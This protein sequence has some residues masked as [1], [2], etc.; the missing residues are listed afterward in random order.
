MAGGDA[1]C[2]ATLRRYE[3]RL[4]RALASV[5]NLVDPDVIVLGGGLSN[6]AR[7]YEN[8]PSQVAPHVFADRSATPIRPPRHG[9]SSGVR[10]AA[11]LEHARGRQLAATTMASPSAAIVAVRPQ[12]RANS[13][14]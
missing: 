8:V 2:E 12:A 14:V 6:M 3:E 13:P 5:V 10:G 7:L 4:G 11:W 1:G 9:D